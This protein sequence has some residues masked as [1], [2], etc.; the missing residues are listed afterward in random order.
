MAKRNNNNFFIQMRTQYGEN[1]LQFIDSR[2]LQL[3]SLQIFRQ[4]AR[5]QVN[6]QEEGKYFL[7]QRLLQAC[8]FSVSNKKEFYE[9]SA[10]GVTALDEKIRSTGQATGATV[11]AVLDYHIRAAEGYNLIYNTLLIINQTR[12]LSVLL[13]LAANLSKYRDYI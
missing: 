7:D 3:K 5:G 9:I 13:T 8:L 6:V 12:D 1:F 2:S 4:I 10:D 11:A